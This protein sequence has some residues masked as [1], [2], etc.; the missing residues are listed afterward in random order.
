M[1]GA[2]IGASISDRYGRK[3]ALALS[4]VPM[5]ITWPLIAFLSNWLLLTFL[6][7][8][9]G[10]GVGIGS[11]V[12]PCYIGEVSTLELRGALGACNQLSI[13][14]GIFF[15]NLFGTFVFVVGDTNEYCQWRHLSLMAAFLAV[16]ITGTAFIPESPR[17]FAKQGNL[18]DTRASLMKLRKVTDSFDDELLEIVNQT[19]ALR[20]ATVTGTDDDG[21]P[22]LT[23]VA[24]SPGPSLE[25]PNLPQE[26]DLTSSIWAPR[27]R[28]SLIVGVGLLLFQQLSG[29]N[30]IIFYV[31]PIC[32]SAGITWANLAGTLAMAAQVIFT[33]IACIVMEK[34]PRRTWLILS[35]T[36]CVLAHI[37]LAGYFIADQHG[38]APPPF[39]AL[40]TITIYIMGFSLGLG[41]IPWLL[42]AELFPT[43]VRGVASSIAIA[44]NWACSFLVTLLFSTLKELL[45]AAGVFLLFGVVCVF[46]IVF[47]ITVV[48]ETRGKNIDEVLGILN[49]D[50]PNLMARPS[51]GDQAR[52][53]LLNASESFS[54]RPR[55]G[56]KV[57][58]TS[59]SEL[60]GPSSLAAGS[61]IS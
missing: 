39:V 25:D 14:F 19:P 53:V 59:E 36:L 24:E 16:C 1:V 6:R 58:A 43:E 10:V 54:T 35:M 18:R 4:A 31:S 22:M 57:S 3:T 50:D 46:G 47:T 27:Y 40:M 42:L 30:A 51:T 56:S 12:A 8:V 23:S 37:G 2:L 13:T 34:A 7:F 29:C 32:K 21:K 9:M 15:A 26:N 55:A 28:M 60:S 11:A 20:R 44:T 41:P 45:G 48:P 17:F 49:N 5:I 52:D 38:Y 61:S 33:F